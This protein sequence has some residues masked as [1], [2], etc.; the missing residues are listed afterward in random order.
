MAGGGAKER[1]GGRWWRR[2]LLAAAGLVA[3]V[4]ACGG[5]GP[6]TSPGA[7]SDAAV[8]QNLFVNPGFEGGEAPWSSLATQVWGTPFQ[9]S[10]EAAHSGQQSAFLQMRASSEL[11]GTGIFGVVQEIAP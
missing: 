6:K 4:A 3:V 5:G 11:G 1:P 7:V 9:V 2:G 8:P 10:R